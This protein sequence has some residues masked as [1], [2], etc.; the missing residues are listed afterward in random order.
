MHGLTWNF[1]RRMVICLSSANPIML[2]SLWA[3]CNL[4]SSFLAHP[5]TGNV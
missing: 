1:Y 5:P 3:R 2:S 4:I